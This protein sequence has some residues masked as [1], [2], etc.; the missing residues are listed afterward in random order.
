MKTVRLSWMCSAFAA[1]ALPVMAQGTKPAEPAKPAAETKPAAA[2]TAT[3]EIGKPAP[4]FALKDL[5]GKE[6]KL[7]SYKGKVVVLEWANSECPVCKN[8][9]KAKTMQNTF[10]AFKDKGVVWL[11]IDSSN[12][13]ETKKDSITKW[14]KDQGTP[15][16][17]LLDAPG[18]V[19]RSYG[20]KTTP[21]M[22]VIDKNGNLAYAGAIDDNKDGDKKTPKN[23]VS[24][25]VTALLAGSAVPTAKTDPYGCSVKYAN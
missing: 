22:F 24:E 25:A 9:Y 20:A 5:D 6:H 14:W 19:G 21:H 23:Y 11:V 15:F 18:K 13:A 3:A 8:H 17:Y 7:S 10:N 16:A 1:M 2:A 12:F 4:D